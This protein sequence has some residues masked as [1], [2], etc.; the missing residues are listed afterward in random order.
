MQHRQ[1]ELGISHVALSNDVPALGQLYVMTAGHAGKY[2]LYLGS[3]R[4][5]CFK[6]YMAICR[7]SLA[8]LRI[9]CSTTTVAV[10]ALAPLKALGRPSKAGESMCLGPNINGRL[11]IGQPVANPGSKCDR[12]TITHI[13]SRDIDD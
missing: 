4:V 8:A 5:I 12:S 13:V 7:I 3:T 9:G 2:V 6:R 1:L 10:L 11:L